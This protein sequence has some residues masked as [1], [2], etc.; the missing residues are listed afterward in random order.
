MPGAI[1][2]APSPRPPT[3]R[4]QL[5]AIPEHDDG[6]IGGFKPDR[7]T[8]TLRFNISDLTTKNAIAP[9]IYT[10]SASPL[11][12]TE[13]RDLGHLE[14]QSLTPDQETFLSQTLSC[15][16]KHGQGI[17]QFVSP[18]AH[19][20][21]P[22]V[23]FPIAR[24][25]TGCLINDSFCLAGET[26][27][28]RAMEEL[29]SDDP[30]AYK[31]WRVTLEKPDG[32]RFLFPV[33]QV[34]MS[35]K[36]NCFDAQALGQVR[37]IVTNHS[38]LIERLASESLIPSA[39]A[40]VSPSGAQPHIISFHG[41]GRNAALITLLEAEKRLQEGIYSMDYIDLLVNNIIHKARETSPFFL[42]TKG[43]RQKDELI[44]YLRQSMPTPHLPSSLQTPA[45]L[46][47]SKSTLQPIGLPNLGST[48][49]ANSAIKALAAMAGEKIVKHL[50]NEATLASLAEEYREPALIFR[51]LVA[52]LI[53]QSQSEAVHLAKLS[54]QAVLERLFRTLQAT[55][56][57]SQ[58]EVHAHSKT[59]VPA[60]QIVGQQHDS[61][62]F[63]GKLSAVFQLKEILNAG[64]VQLH[65]VRPDQVDKDLSKVVSMQSSTHIGVELRPVSPDPI[66]YSKLF[67]GL[68]GFEQVQSRGH[69]EEWLSCLDLTDS[70][71]SLDLSIRPYYRQEHVAT[72]GNR[73]NASKASEHLIQIQDINYQ[74]PFN[75]TVSTINPNEYREV[76]LTPSVIICHSGGSLTGGH[77]WMSVQGGDGQWQ[78][79]NDDEVI[80]RESPRNDGLPVFIRFEITNNKRV[81]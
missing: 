39:D 1:R 29:P 61:L 25:L 73:N 6:G 22:S 5:P 28:L 8:T 3:H 18:A 32:T 9:R 69:T 56:M 42:R 47:A 13:Q 48:C 77:Y 27:T 12:G 23:D 14:S 51:S 53:G 62:E 68:L 2:S 10:T 50:S 79:H 55:S 17:F 72:R 44:K 26:F 37:R 15:A 7:S 45:D 80:P 67:Q 58:T 52:R 54:T 34:G 19:H 21:Q 74:L 76:T 46:V 30:S 31:Q 41:I 81:A 63:L 57:F 16:I 70:S 65:K 43:G 33:T 40:S 49:Y 78:E 24:F 35:Y 36:D 64:G 66:T 11:G 20:H 38:Q 60:F 59:R 71:M 75:L 4:S